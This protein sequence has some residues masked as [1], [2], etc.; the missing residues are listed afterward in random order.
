[1]SIYLLREQG[2]SQNTSLNSSKCKFMLISRKRN[3][4]T[5]PPTITINGNALETVPTFKYLGL[6]FTSDLSWSRHIEGVCTK[7]KKILGLLYRRFYQHA[8]QQTL[9]QLYISIVRP[10]MEY[11]APVWDPHL[12][13]DQDLLE[14]TQ[15]F[16]CKVMTKTWDRGYDELLNMTNLPSLTDRTL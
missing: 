4:M 8:D 12:R 2:Y 11:A 9:R 1:M 15:K 5:N 14:S 6:L 10:H 13:K 16:A 7:A 3:R